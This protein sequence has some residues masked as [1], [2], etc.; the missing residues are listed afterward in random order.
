MEVWGFQPKN[1][2]QKLALHFL[3]NSLAALLG[4][5]KPKNVFR[6][7]YVAAGVGEKLD[8]YQDEATSSS[9]ASSP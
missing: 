5:A 2:T 6:S 7:C 8:T 3:Y 1:I 4:I 9:Q